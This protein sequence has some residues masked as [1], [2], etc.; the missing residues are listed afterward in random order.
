MLQHNRQ[1][2]KRSTWQYCSLNPLLVLDLSYSTVLRWV[3]KFVYLSAL[4]L[5]GCLVDF[6]LATSHSLQQDSLAGTQ[7]LINNI[8]HQSHSMQEAEWAQNA[9]GE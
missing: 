8:A 9:A 3:L 2:D 5:K 4:T 6:R 1:C 7:S